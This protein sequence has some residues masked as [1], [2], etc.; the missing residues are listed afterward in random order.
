MADLLANE[1]FTSKLPMRS[2]ARGDPVRL[3][4]RFGLEVS[5][6][7]TRFSLHL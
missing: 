5:H 4:S 7:E 6:Y 1:W 2:A 3:T